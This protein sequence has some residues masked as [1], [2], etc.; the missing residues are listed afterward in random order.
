MFETVK[1]PIQA[2]ASCTG[3]GMLLIGSAIGLASA[4]QA[5]VPGQEYF[6]VGGGGGMLTFETPCPDIPCG[7]GNTCTCVTST[8][9]VKFSTTAATLTT[10]TYT[11]E[12]STAVNSAMPNGAGNLCYF[13]SGTLGLTTPKGTLTIPFS[14]PACRIGAKVTGP[15]ATPLGTASVAYIAAGTGKY[16]NPTGVGSFTGTFNPFTQNVLFDLVGYGI[17]SQ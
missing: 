2:L 7:T 16:H 11:L 10:G 17:L 13:A 9:T 3:L 8:G 5:G 1:R 6:T 15:D 4:A 12:V 14:G